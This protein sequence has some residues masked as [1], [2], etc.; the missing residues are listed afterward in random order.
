[1]SKQ[2]QDTAQHTRCCQ[3]AR[4]FRPE[5]INANRR[6]QQFMQRQPQILDDGP[7]A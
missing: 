4:N 7:F 2:L 3:D 6:L 1:M 5:S